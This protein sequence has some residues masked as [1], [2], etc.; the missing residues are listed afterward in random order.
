[1]KDTERSCKAEYIKALKKHNET[2]KKYRDEL[3]GTS[4][5]V[6][7]LYAF[8]YT[9]LCGKGETVIYKSD[10]VTGL[11]EYRCDVCDRG[12]YY[13]VSVRKKDSPDTAD[14]RNA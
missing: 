2:I 1:M 12:E 3:K 10:V 5:L 14:K 7:L 11:E 9:L 8:I 4:E 13:T 6:E